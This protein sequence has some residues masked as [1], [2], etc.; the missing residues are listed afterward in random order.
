MSTL[1]RLVGHVGYL[2][3]YLDR[4]SEIPLCSD[5]NESLPLPDL[6][7]VKILWPNRY[8]WSGGSLCMGM[9]KEALASIVPVELRD[10]SERDR[11]WHER[12]GFPV[13]GDKTSSLGKPRNPKFPNDIRGDIFE[14]QCGSRRIRC[15]YD[16]SDFPIV[17]TEIAGQVDL[18]FKC[19]T[20]KTQIPANVASVGYFPSRPRLLA[21]A[22]R[23]VFER[24]VTK[25]IDVYGR[26]GTWTD[27][28]EIREKL[29]TRMQESSV[30]FQG[31]FGTIVFPAYLKELMRTRVALDAPGN[32]PITYRLP[33]AMA[34]GAVV[35]CAPP[36]C[37][38]PEALDNGVHY[39][40]TRADGSDVIEVCEE[41]LR[42]Q[43]RMAKIARNGMKFFDRN[44]SPQ[45]RARRILRHAVALT[46]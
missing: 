33:E 26:F 11:E 5:L 19:V 4:P 28:Q 40:A 41:L 37:V 23:M 16:Y 30:R 8:S 25:N 15:A 29:V 36:E 10:V 3:W 12:G 39:A 35:V 7:D 31:G 46:K 42:D 27:S 2:N 1:N 32:A 45:S 24:P 20:P 17:S 18:Y 14:V 38:F 6:T 21:R 34:L 13:P 43:D 44:F 22:R 9:V